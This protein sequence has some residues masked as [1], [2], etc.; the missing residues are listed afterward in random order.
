MANKLVFFSAP[1]RNL[2]QPE[3]LRPQLQLPSTMNTYLLVVFIGTTLVILASF[4]VGLRYG[5]W[6]GQKPDPEPLLPARMILS[7][8]LSLLAFLLTFTFGLALSHYD[9]RSDAL[10]A[11]AVAISTSY[12]RTALLAEPERT[13]LRTLIR[14]YVDLR[15]QT[16]R[17]KNVADADI[18]RLRQLQERI[19]LEATDR[20][21]NDT[22]RTPPTLLL[23]SLNDMID[24]Q[25]ER[26]L[27]NMRSRIP[28]AIWAFLG[29]AIVICVIGT[30]YHS[31]LA[32]NRRRSVAA[33]TYALVFAAVTVMIAD[34]DFPRLG[35][36]EASYQ[37]LLDLRTRLHSLTEKME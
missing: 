9:S 5:R 36:F 12:H 22:D 4:E 25:A 15:L 21:E 6:R 20:G 24:V 13:R 31:G 37:E 7:G 16:S 27:T 34:A 2:T 14:E 18:A 11:E 29:S 33:V 23:Q 3:K 10:H 19:W 35:Q 17:S 30:G 32:G 8:V 28:A 1:L 26:V